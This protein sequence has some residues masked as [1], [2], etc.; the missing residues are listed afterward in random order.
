MIK[1]NFIENEKKTIKHLLK[2][3]KKMKGF[4]E[5]IEKTKWIE[6]DEILTII[7][8]ERIKKIKI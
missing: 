4:M 6:Q 2:K 7:P 8:C 5:G 1:G 3:K